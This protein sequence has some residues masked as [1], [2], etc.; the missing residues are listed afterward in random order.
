MNAKG[1]LS[2]NAIKAIMTPIDMLKLSIKQKEQ[3]KQYM[4]IEKKNKTPCEASYKVDKK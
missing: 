2:D 1:Q 4:D 3:L